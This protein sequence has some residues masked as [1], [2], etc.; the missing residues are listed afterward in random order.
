[1]QVYLQICSRG[2]N[3]R[4]HEEDERRHDDVRD[5]SKT[6]TTLGKRSAAADK[7]TSTNGAAQGDELCMTRLQPALRARA[8]GCCELAACIV[9]VG[10]DLR[11]LRSLVVYIS[12]GH[13]GY[14]CQREVSRDKREEEK[15]LPLLCIRSKHGRSTA[16]H[17]TAQHAQHLPTP[18]LR[19]ILI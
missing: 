12:N 7:K 17:N 11:L 15:M 16:Q 8:G 14:G 13:L 9:A 3:G 10:V 18:R 5:Q 19:K 6:R 2:R 4:D 1:M